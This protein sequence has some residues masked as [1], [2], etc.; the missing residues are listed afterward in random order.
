MRLEDGKEQEEVAQGDDGAVTAAVGCARNSRA[1][2]LHHCSPY[3]TTS[4]NDKIREEMQRKQQE[5]KDRKEQET[6]ST[7]Q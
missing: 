2:S 3:A 1:S 6:K 5:R 4:Y 7:E